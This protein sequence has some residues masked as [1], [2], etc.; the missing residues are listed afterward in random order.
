[1]LH[2]WKI[3]IAYLDR[4]RASRWPA[5]N[6]PSHTISPVALTDAQVWRVSRKHDRLNNVILI[7]AP[8][9]IIGRRYVTPLPLRNLFFPS[10]TYRETSRGTRAE[11]L[12]IH[13]SVSL[14]LAPSLPL[15]VIRRTFYIRDI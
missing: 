5:R 4:S 14:P 10:Y 13:L 11:N 7:A 6:G 3:R 15:R 8:L 2:S 12:S 9:T 1:M